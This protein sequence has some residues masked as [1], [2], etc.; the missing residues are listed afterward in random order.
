MSDPATAKQTGAISRTYIGAD[1]TKI[2][3]AKTL[4]SPIGIVRLSTDDE[5]LGGLFLAE[6]LETAL[7]GL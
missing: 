1:L 6:G 5:V 2:G 7:A 4:G 3:K